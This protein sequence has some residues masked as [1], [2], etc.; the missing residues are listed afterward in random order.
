MCR[1]AT[2]SR[3]SA[4]WLSSRRPRSRPRHGFR[5]IEK[6]ALAEQLAQEAASRSEAIAAGRVLA[7]EAAALDREMV[8]LLDRSL[9]A[10][11]DLDRRIGDFER[12]AVSVRAL[13]GNPGRLDRPSYIGR[14]WG[15]ATLGI[16]RLRREYG[17]LSR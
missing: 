6:D 12:R 17:R 7:Q 2:W 1:G 16:E 11:H 13:G 4:A 3:R 14:S 5:V 10:L 15:D 8:E 9:A